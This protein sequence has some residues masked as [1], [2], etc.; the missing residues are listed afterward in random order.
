VSITV[1]NSVYTTQDTLAT[2]DTYW[3]DVQAITLGNA[4]LNGW[5]NTVTI[6]SHDGVGGVSEKAIL[7]ALTIDGDPVAAPEPGTLM[8]F[9]TGLA[10][11]AFLRRKSSTKA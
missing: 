10:G 11:L 7:S 2:P 9:G 5:L 8:L 4:F 3:L 6:T 1:Y